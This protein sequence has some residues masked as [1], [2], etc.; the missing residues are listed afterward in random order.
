MRLYGCWQHL[1]LIGKYYLHEYENLKNHE[2]ISGR[3]YKILI[4]CF[5]SVAQKF[6]FEK[7]SLHH[8]FERVVQV[9][10]EIAEKVILWPTGEKLDQVKN[11]FKEIAGLKGI[12]GAIDGSFIPIKAPEV[13]TDINFNT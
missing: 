1:T 2:I 11:R 9:L 10:N 5:R 8:C 4:C 3:V 6:D 12:I 7:S 13:C